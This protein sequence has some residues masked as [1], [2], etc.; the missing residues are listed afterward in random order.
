MLKRLLVLA[1]VATLGGLTTG[2]CTDNSG[3]GH[4]N[5]NLRP[6]SG[7]SGGSGATGGSGGADMD[8]GE[9]GAGGTTDA[10]DDTAT[11]P[12]GNEDSLPVDGL[13]LDGATGN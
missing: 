12:D 5:P 1:L 7:G 3:N 11:S 8:G 4:Y 9:D 2:G 6:S 10:S 13:N